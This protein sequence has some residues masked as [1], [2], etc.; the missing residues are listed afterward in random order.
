MS[1]TTS[2][3]KKEI[4]DVLGENV[5][6]IQFVNEA[7]LLLVLM[8]GDL[9]KT[10]ALMMR[11]EIATGGP[12]QVH[13]PFDVVADRV[14]WELKC[15]ANMAGL[16]SMCLE[17]VGDMTNGRDS[18]SDP[19]IELHKEAVKGLNMI[20]QKAE[21]VYGPIKRNEGKEGGKTD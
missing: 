18:A 7:A 12:D 14:K 5:T 1:E 15:Q 6:N 4:L 13:L 10:D 11:I 19:I 21:K 20:I 16:L 8:L 17:L 3:S 9:A 2:A